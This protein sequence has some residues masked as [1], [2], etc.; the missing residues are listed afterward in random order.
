MF[1]KMMY[2]SG[3]V[4]VMEALIVCCHALDSCS[5]G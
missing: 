1:K 2:F 4:I 3:K 5:A